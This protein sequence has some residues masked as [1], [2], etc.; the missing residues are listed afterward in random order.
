MYAQRYDGGGKGKSVGLG[1][2]IAV[3]AGLLALLMTTG[4]VPT[5]IQPDKPLIT[6]HIP[7]DLT[8]PPEPI[9]QP[10][11][12]RVEPSPAPLPFTPEPVVDLPM[13]APDM[14]TTVILPPLPPLPMPSSGTGM[15]SGGGAA[16]AEP[17]PPALVGASIDPRFAGAFQPDYPAAE[18]RAEREG[19]VVVR[20]LIG[21]DGRVQAVE[22][23]SAVSPGL[24]EATRR[25]AL[26]RWRFKPATRGGVPVES[27]K[28]MTLRF[29]LSVG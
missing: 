14:T 29:E 16:A 22:Q 17:T 10:R 6:E 5:I 27:W 24:F 11:V 21:I 4:V 25:H 12:D 15:G 26:A 19:R 7:L 28:T 18:R 23:V 3:N 20:V 2:A 8:P 9:E 1:A 13:P